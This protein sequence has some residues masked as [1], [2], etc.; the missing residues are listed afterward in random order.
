MN[1][2]SPERTA[3]PATFA[4]EPSGH[5]PPQK[6]FPPGRR[7]AGHHRTRFLGLGLLLAM[8]T[9]LGMAIAD[10]PSPAVLPGTRPLEA[11]TGGLGNWDAVL[12]AAIREAREGRPGRWHRDLSSAEALDRSI[13]TNRSRFAEII[14][15]RDPRVA[16]RSPT[17][18]ATLEK[19]AL[20]AKRATHE[21]LRVR[22]PAFGQ[23]HGEGLLLEPRGRRPIAAVVAVPD[24]AQTPEQVAGLEP[25]VAPESQFARRLAESGCRVLVP[26]LI[27]RTIEV[28]GREG[29][30]AYSR[31]P[32][33]SREFLFRPAFQLG[34]HLIGYEVQKILAGVDWMAGGGSP[35]GVIGHGEGGL[36]AFYAAAIDT[37]IRATGVSGY[38]DAR[39]H[40]WSEP[41]DRSVFSLLTR[42]GDAEIATMILPR[43][44]LIEACRA[45]EV[46]V[47]APGGSRGVVRSPDI[48]TVR[49]EVQ[50]ADRLMEGLQ[51]PARI[52]LITSGDDG[53]GPFATPALLRAFL[54]A[55]APGAALGDP[56][57]GPESEATG[58]DPKPRQLRQVEELERHTQGLLARSA[59]ER[60]RFLSG[61][62]S[63]S[64]ERHLATKGR[65]V[66][67]LRREVLGRIETPRSDIAARSRLRYDEPA[68]RCYEVQLEV[69]PGA[70]ASGL[71]VLPKTL[72]PGGRRPVVVCQHGG[73]GNPDQLVRDGAGAY[74]AFAARLAEEGFVT[75]SPSVMFPP[76]DSLVRKCNSLGLTQYSY[77]AAMHQQIVDWLRTQP[78]V[79]PDRIALYGLS[80]GGKTAMRM[81]LL[82]DGYAM[83]IVSGDFNEWTWKTTTTE[84]DYSY[85]FQPEPYIFEFNLGGT[86]GYAEMAAL[87]APRPF[88]VERGHSDPVGTDEQVGFEFAKVRHLYAARLGLPENCAIEWFVGGHEIHRVGTSRFL[89]HHLDR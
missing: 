25:G 49:S 47:T 88:M 4:M 84:S 44:L 57:H 34:R 73:G 65:Y 30:R 13:A 61:L 68:W 77:I 21:V 40:H 37:R 42:F 20:V 24:C 5:L 36:L 27:D 80:W 55:L 59:Q 83:T 72:R 58:F 53:Q 51:P 71:L 63:S 1:T 18:V 67:H 41:F 43:R 8:A 14:G 6:S 79:E 31:Q 11:G 45:P 7:P 26:V 35:V 12:D 76:P 10:D 23:V 69:F 28:R 74:H 52:E 56:G 15:V 87:I 50:R 39:D 17:L 70:N 78:F 86:Y 62:D 60:A 82:V 89:H 48:R 2:R 3:P 85:V 64:L 32:M 81:P 16:F 66:D 54:G 75:F 33:S 19:P 22:W 38:F 9:S 46:S 29:F